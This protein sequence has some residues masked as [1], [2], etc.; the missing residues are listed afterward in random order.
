MQ[1]C[2][3]CG[4]E[5]SSNPRY[6]RYVCRDCASRASASDGKRLQFGQSGPT[7]ELEARYAET[8]AP[9]PRHDCWIDGQ[10]CRAIVA[11]FGGIVIQVA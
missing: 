8:G 2:P 6:P 5:V 3:I 10:P 1:L 11:H 4:C 9:Y 7:G